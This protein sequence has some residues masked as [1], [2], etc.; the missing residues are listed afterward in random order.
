MSW[1][2]TQH[3]LAE[4]QSDEEIFN[5]V[6]DLMS[7]L[8]TISVAKGRRRNKSGTQRRQKTNIHTRR[9]RNTMKKQSQKTQRRL[10]TIPDST[11]T[12]LASLATDPLRVTTRPWQAENR[13]TAIE[14]QKLFQ[15]V[16]FVL[17]NRLDLI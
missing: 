11:A 7:R 5:F 13:P 1:V 6:L 2:Y 12:L 9:Q 3:T 15:K 17:C 10:E 14:R 4:M 8:C 16:L